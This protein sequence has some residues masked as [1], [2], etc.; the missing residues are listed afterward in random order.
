MGRYR[1]RA[2]VDAPLDPGRNPYDRRAEVQE[3]AF[4]R[5][6]H[7]VDLRCLEE[8][9]LVRNFDPTGHVFL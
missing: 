3:M 7:A 6:K 8:P 2:W 4:A 5:L 1:Q 9:P